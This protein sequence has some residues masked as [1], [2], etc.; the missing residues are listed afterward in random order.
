MCEGSFPLAYDD[1]KKRFF[2][3]GLES[4]S[5]PPPPRLKFLVTSD[6]WTFL[7]SLMLKA[8]KFNFRKVQFQKY[9]THTFFFYVERHSYTQFISKFS[10]LVTFYSSQIRFLFTHNFFIFE[11]KLNSYKNLKNK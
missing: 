4:F 7:C 10:F 3:D 6:L 11:K 9:Q 5:P 2:K 8:S 1:W